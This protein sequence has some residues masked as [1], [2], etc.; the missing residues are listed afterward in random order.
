MEKH[1]LELGKWYSN[2]DQTCYIKPME[3]L[4]PDNRALCVFI[5]TDHSHISVYRNRREAKLLCAEHYD[6]LDKIHVPTEVSLLVA[7][8]LLDYKPGERNSFPFHKAEKIKSTLKLF[9]KSAT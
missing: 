9:R 3:E 6:L 2:K 4:G 5:Q 1:N 8:L 7:S